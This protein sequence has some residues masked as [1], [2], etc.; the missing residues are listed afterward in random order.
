MK[1]LYLTNSIYGSGGL[2]RVLSLK[3]NY[4][5]KN[6]NYEVHIVAYDNHYE[7]IYEIDSHVNLH[8]IKIIRNSLCN[9]LHY[10]FEARK[11][12]KTINPDIISVC[13]DGFKGFL[14]P[15]LLNCTI[16]IIYERHM[17]RIW[18]NKKRVNKILDSCIPYL[19]KKFSAVILLTESNRK[20]WKDVKN[21]LVISDPLPFYPY[22]KSS[23]LNKKII[24]VGKVTYFK[25]F[26][27]LA[28]A[29]AKIA[30][31]YPDWSV[32]IYG[33]KCEEYQEIY[34]FCEENG[35]TNSFIMH[36]P[37]KNIYDQYLNSSIYVLS[38]RFE[39]FGMVLIEAMSCGLPC[40]SFDCPCGPRDIIQNGED[41][42][43]VEY[44]NVDELVKKIKLLID[45]RNLRV[46][47]GE[48]ARKNV[49]RYEVN[50]ICTQWNN[51]FK[52]LI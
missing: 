48:N 8:L 1:I 15:L 38:S 50:S 25:G 17:P 23:L 27:Y 2:E 21:V 42:F 49:L 19:S 12:I 36:D 10:I 45:D 16:P 9:F 41:G 43:L 47:M 40:V 51:L 32:H 7:Q 34:T 11:L 44:L 52:K 39:G 20:E 24:A 14:L 4:F 3:S 35:L 26:I 33:Q 13:D 18:T 28:Q 46:E 22:K 5:V 29:W 37:V 6:Y 30:S 31:Q